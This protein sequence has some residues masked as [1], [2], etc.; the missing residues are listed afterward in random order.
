MS[1][2]APRTELAIDDSVWLEVDSC[3]VDQFDPTLSMVGVFS[4]RWGRG[5]D[6]CFG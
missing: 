4:D 5:V 1:T 6:V 3:G 2:S